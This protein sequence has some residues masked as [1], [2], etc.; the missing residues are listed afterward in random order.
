MRTAESAMRD[1]ECGMRNAGCGM[2]N[3]ESAMR[4]AECGV[5]NA[6]PAMRNPHAGRSEKITM[7]PH[8][9]FRIP[10][11]YEPAL[12]SQLSGCRRGIKG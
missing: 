7:G 5:R 6:E 11:K 10:Q 12:S 4:D 9:A 3:A 8:S 1:A 2:R